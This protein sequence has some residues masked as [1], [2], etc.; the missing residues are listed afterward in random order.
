MLRRRL[1]VAL[2]VAAAAFA[3]VPAQAG[4]SPEETS[5]AAVT[6]LNAYWSGVFSELGRTYSPPAGIVWYGDEGVSTRCGVTRP[7]NAMYCTTDR[8]IYLD[9]WLYSHFAVELG[10]PFAVTVVIAHEW[11]HAIQDEFGL[12]RPVRR[13]N[14]L[15]TEQQADCYA[16]LYTRYEDQVGALGDGDVG[17]GIALMV[18]AGDPEGIPGPFSHGTSDV[19]VRNFLRGY[20]T[21]DLR[22][23]ESVLF[24]H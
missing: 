21:G 19:R 16:G 24:G 11:G 2:A 9:R 17:A 5:A 4:A 23:C 20:A 6:G 8:T 10:L 14:L 7:H 22:A 15:W 1:V 18:A 13:R 12:F 3:L